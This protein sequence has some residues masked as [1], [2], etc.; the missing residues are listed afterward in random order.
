MW[1]SHSPLTWFTAC[2]LLNR[3][4]EYLCLWL[5]CIVS[6]VLS[7]IIVTYGTAFLWTWN[8]D[9]YILIIVQWDATQNS[10]FIIQQVLSTC[11]GCQPHPSSGVHKSV[12]TSSGTDYIFCAATSFQQGQAWSQWGSCTKNMTSIGGCSCSF[13][14]CISSKLETCEWVK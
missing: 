9:K 14:Y 12:T 13:M 2:C 3:S 11:F 6:W 1:M 10:L 5:C 8:L 7:I 4:R